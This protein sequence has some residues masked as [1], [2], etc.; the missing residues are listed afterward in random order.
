MSNDGVA[1][2]AIARATSEVVTTPPSPRPMG[3]VMATCLVTGN[4][5]GSGVFLL[6]R[7]LSAFGWIAIIAWV[8]TGV[9]SL[10]Q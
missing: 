2:E 4:M 3:T 9:G 6:P 7:V 1:A 8:V 10:L 5:I